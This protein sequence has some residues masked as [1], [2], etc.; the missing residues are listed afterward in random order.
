MDR[1]R[2]KSKAGIIGLVVV[3]VIIAVLFGVAYIGYKQFKI[4]KITIEGT[5]KYT[6]DELYKYIFANRNDKNV[7]LFKLTDS[8]NE[9]PDIPFI[10]KVA[11]EVKDSHT[12]EVTVYEKSIVGYV[13]YKGTNM[14]FDKDGVIV[15]TSTKQLADTSLVKGLEFDSIVMH[16]KL[17]VGDDSIF[18]DLLDV[19]QYLDKYGIVT[20]YIRVGEN[21][22]IDIALGDVMVK[23]GKNN[24]NMGEKVYELSCLKDKLE[25]LKGTLHMEEYTADKEYIT[26]IESE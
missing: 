4:E 17:E 11:I 2:R 26:F 9:M 16:Q 1:G 23:L 6:Y 14:Y 8:R 7:L 3:L 15:E 22:E 20:D 12:L 21:Y 19:T 18:T 13:E 25:G 24:Y 10:S 5:D